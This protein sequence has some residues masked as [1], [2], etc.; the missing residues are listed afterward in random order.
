MIKQYFRL[1]GQV[2]FSTISSQTC[3]NFVF[4]LG[5]RF[6]HDGKGMKVVIEFVVIALVLGV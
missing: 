4:R 1:N 6:V 5:D 3:L 2:D